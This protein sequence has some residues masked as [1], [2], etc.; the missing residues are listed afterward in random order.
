MES[1]EKKD[2]VQRKALKAW[3]KSNKKGSCEIIT[4]LGKTFISLHALYT[5]P[6]KD[7]KINLFLAETV[8]RKKDLIADIQKYNKIFNRNVL[9]D[10]ILKFS[11]YQSAYKW[12]NKKFGLVI[13]DEIQDQLTPSYFK[14]HLYNKYDAI[15]GLSATIDKSRKYVI[16]DNIYTKIDL[17][18]KIAPICFK[19][20]INKA[21]EEK[22][23]R[24]LRIV[25]INNELDS[26]TKNI[27]AGSKTKKFFQTEKE[28]Y[29]Y[30]DKRHK[31]AWFIENMERQ[32][33]EIR[34]TSQKR[35]NLLFNLPSKIETTK[36]LINSL[37]KKTIL[38]GNSL[39]ALLKITPNIINSRNSDEKNNLIRQ[40]FDSNK[41]KVIGSFKK[42]KQGANLKSLDNCVIMSFYSSEK[43][44][45]QRIGR[46]R[47]NGQ[48]GTVFI[49][50]TKNTQEEIWFSKMLGNNSIFLEWYN[51]I[52]DYLNKN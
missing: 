8:E 35:S 14:F 42:L 40:K 49:I 36:K 45:I 29:N 9:N 1:I 32:Q 50:L 31:K 51:N 11:C 34:I 24:K 6:K 23:T 10:Y 44:Y 43:D 17:L 52:D 26:K 16:N 48:E 46:L 4:G 25:V 13:C 47:D 7:G 37:N 21:R 18:N 39:D 22:T 27:P 3:I 12:K 19:Y 41:I 30:W 38:F 33:L 15:I 2:K 28:A 5:M 20:N